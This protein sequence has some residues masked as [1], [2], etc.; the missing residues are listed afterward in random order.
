[1]ALLWTYDYVHLGPGFTPHLD[2]DFASSPSGNLLK[3]WTTDLFEDVDSQLAAKITLNV[4]KAAT[5][6]HALS[7]DSSHVY[8]ASAMQQ[9]QALSAHGIFSEDHAADVGPNLNQLVEADGSTWKSITGQNKAVW[10]NTINDWAQ[11]VA[12]KATESYSHTDEISNGGEQFGEGMLLGLTAGMVYHQNWRTTTTTGQ[13]VADWINQG[14]REY[15]NLFNS[16]APGVVDTN[17][18][19]TNGSPPKSCFVAGT[20]VATEHGAVA[21]QD[22]REGHHILTSADP[23]TYGLCSDEEVVHSLNSTILC[24]ISKLPIDRIRTVLTSH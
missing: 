13:Q 7:N 24:G 9:F 18:Y 17:D 21:I 22:L 12:T 3:Q 19:S 10:E 8:V 1:M 4:T 23:I 11:A 16:G 2:G 15:S 14:S 20:S 5:L 6:V